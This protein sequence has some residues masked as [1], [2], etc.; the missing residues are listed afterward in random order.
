[1][2]SLI[3]LVEL[4]RGRRV[5]TRGDAEADVR[6]DARA[7]EVLPALVSALR[8]GGTTRTSPQ[9]TPRLR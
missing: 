1:V 2:R 6:V 7:G 3:E 5:T 4:L 8:G 9:P